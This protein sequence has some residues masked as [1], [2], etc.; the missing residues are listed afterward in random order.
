MK[1]IVKIIAL[2]AITAFAVLSCGPE[3]SLSGVDWKTVNTGYDPTKNSKEIEH[4]PFTVDPT[5]SLGTGESAKNEVVLEFH[6]AADMLKLKLTETEAALREFLTFHTFA[7]A[8]APQ[9]GKA[10]E[11][12]PELT[13]TYVNRTGDTFTLKLE[14]TFNANS[15]NV[16]AKI[17]GTKYTFMNGNKMDRANRGKAGEALYDDFYADISV[18]GI[19]SS[20]DF[21]P[22]GN[23]EW[24]FTLNTMLSPPSTDK[25]N[26]SL[27]A[28]L[29]LLDFGTGTERVTT[30]ALKAL[31]AGELKNG[32]KVEEFVN[33]EWNNTGATITVNSTGFIEANITY[34][35]CV[36][37]RVAWE[38]DAPFIT[39]DNYF[40]VKQWVSI[41][42]ANTDGLA[43]SVVYQTKKVYGTPGMW[44]S[45]KGLS[46][47]GAN[48]RFRSIEPGISVYAS[49]A[50]NQS[51]ILQVGPIPSR[52][53]GG[54]TYWLKEITDAQLF[55]DN[56]KIAY[57]DED[58]EGVNIDDG[59][60][61]VDTDPTGKEFFTNSGMV[62][63]PIEKFEF[64][65]IPASDNTNL[66]GLNG[67]RITLDPQYR[68]D[69]DKT[70]Y[71]YISPV[72]RLSDDKVT[73][74][75][76][77]NWLYNFFRVY[78]VGKTF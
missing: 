51:V 60:G 53:D 54:T 22:P 13:Y 12:G 37:I 46:G 39:A 69:R 44:Y 45:D 36:P 20:S 17:D 68:I 65:K 15:S 55:Q 38:G 77:E 23:K 27:L 70:K 5:S 4:T 40:G 1:I 14:T 67:I 63:I 52:T 48:I 71:F 57:Y 59:E 66:E 73:F 26:E 43:A 49:D 78:N 25:D 75:S 9:D 35:D 56:F 31:I 41:L 29:V 18:A 24:S 42:G 30:D 34:K 76:P 28:T 58:I 7:E 21:F 11:L 8:A 2:V 62:F 33:G 3:A 64:V 16:V 10:D 32:L 19:N 6:P 50:N 61:I 72:I 74:G 47:S